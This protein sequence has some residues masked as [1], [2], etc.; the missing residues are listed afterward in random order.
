MDSEMF[1]NT[2]RVGREGLRK[3]IRVRICVYL[4]RVQHSKRRKGPLT[5]SISSRQRRCDREPKYGYIYRGEANEPAAGR[6]DNRLTPVKPLQPRNNWP[7]SSPLQ[8]PPLSSIFLRPTSL[9]RQLCGRQRPQIILSM[10]F[11][12][13]DAPISCWCGPRCG[14]HSS[15]TRLV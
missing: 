9:V 12:L 1:C 13:S 14:H 10:P 5:R 3:D 2:C 15:G 11:S 6:G 4:E 7:S 8:S